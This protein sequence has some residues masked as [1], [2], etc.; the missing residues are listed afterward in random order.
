[1]KIGGFDKLSW[2][3]QELEEA[4]R[5]EERLRHLEEV[6]ELPPPV[7]ETLEEFRL[8]TCEGVENPRRALAVGEVREIPTLSY[9]IADKLLEGRITQEAWEEALPCERIEM[10]NRA[11]GIM[12]EQMG[13]PE[14][15]REQAK[16][17][18]ADLSADQ[19]GECAI[20]LL[21][22]E[23][24]E[25]ALDPDAAPRVTLDRDLAFREDI[26]IPLESLLYQ[27]TAVMEQICCVEPAGSF[28]DRAL[29][30]AWKEELSAGLSGELVQGESAMLKYS[31]DLEEAFWTNY[32]NLELA[33]RIAGS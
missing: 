30:E 8:R 18:L 24:G 7:Y 16:L 10:M 23:S 26:Q 13:L 27:A 33:K 2:A 6:S 1:M 22:D 28:S 12:L 32:Q 20:V 4:N 3:E 29:L 15:V 31:R 17:Q 21:R 9:N 14:T 11:F 5:A 25:L 19:M